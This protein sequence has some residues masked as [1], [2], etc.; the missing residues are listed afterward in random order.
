MSEFKHI[1]S[2]LKEPTSE[3]KELVQKA[4]DFALEAHKDQKRKSGEPYF[5]HLFETA[6]ILADLGMSATTVSAGL[7]HDTVED[8]GVTSEKIEEEFGGE[9]RFL[10][11]GVTKLGNLKYRG[12]TRHSESLRKLF[13]AMS[14][15][16]RV[17]II[18]LSDRLHNM[19]T[20]SHVPEE[21]QYRI[22]KETLEI[23]APIAYRLGIRKLH[24][25][26]EDLAFK[27]CL[28]DEYKKIETLVKQIQG[29]ELESL[30]KFHRAVKKSFAS[31]NFTDFHTDYRIKG[32]YSL[33]KKLRRK[34]MDIEKVHDIAA[35]RVIVPTVSDCYRALGIIHGEYRPL[36]GR[37][38]DYI[39]FP[40]TNGY[41]ALHTTVFNGDGG[42]VEVQIKTE[43]MQKESE[44]GITSHIGYKQN[45]NTGDMPGKKKR[46][47]PNLE[48]IRRILPV[49]FAQV[50]SQKN[51]TIS[52]PSKQKSVNLED[53]PRWVKDLVEYQKDTTEDGFLDDLKNDFFHE[54]IFIFTPRGDVVDLPLG[55]SVVDFAYSIHSDIGNTT[56]SAKVNGKFVAISTI[57][58]NGDR[59]EIETKK[60]A[61][62][63]RKWLDF[64][65]TTLAKRHIRLALSEKTK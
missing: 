22:A 33:H 54:R 26:L 37:I 36:P 15:D 43:D 35:L 58:H 31:E 28:P 1:I 60:N 38:K 3:D 57:L 14:Q 23:Y 32:S 29:A 40:K 42:I 24:R 39:A 52:E 27:Y 17:L 18:K 63:N 34:D 8:T 13:V 56:A 47:N 65:K 30:E 49:N 19:R 12:T 53:V 4:Y 16:I 44:Y 64:C 55:S 46:S 9:I 11:D 21:K 6:K 45:Q 5:I 62:P 20:L 25:E 10:V 61:R 7:L 51:Q 59:V 50:S 48:W 2:L 41:Q